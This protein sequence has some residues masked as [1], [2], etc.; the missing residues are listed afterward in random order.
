MGEQYA[1]RI[2]G[3]ARGVQQGQRVVGRDR[4]HPGRDLAGIGRQPFPAKRR[5]VGPRQVPVA[6]RAGRRVADDDLLDP[7][8]LVEGRLPA[9]ELGG[10]VEHRHPGVAVRGHVGDLL[11]GQR[12]VQ[13]HAKAARVHR[14]EVGNHVLAAVRQHQRDPLAGRQPER[15]EPGRRLE[16]PLPRLLPG[17]GVP[18][19][20]GPVPASSAYAPASPA[21][22]ATCRSSSHSVRP[23]IAS[24]ISARCRAM[25]AAHPVLRPRRR[26]R[27]GE[28]AGGQPIDPDGPSRAVT[29][30]F[31]VYVTAKK[32]DHRVNLAAWPAGAAGPAPASAAAGAG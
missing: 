18:A 6:G 27:D 29:S 28:S 32:R 13:R 20:A 16:H 17:Q 5:E 21:V 9:V 8:Q 24:S 22:S 10:P 2:A 19:I 12:G 7:R 30:H 3:G 31:G 4:R 25:S 26:G 11:G 14:P 23:A 1:L 15:G